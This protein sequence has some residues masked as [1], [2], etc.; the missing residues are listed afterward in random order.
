MPKM[1][2]DLEP[3]T[4]HRYFAAEANNRAWELAELPQRDAAQEREML[5]VAHASA[6]HWAAVGTELH[7]MRYTAL[8]AEVHALVGDGE[9]ALAYATQMRD[10]FLAQA[11][12]P[13]WELALT[14][15]IY[16]HAAH[17]AGRK[18]A[19][20]DSYRLAQQAMDAIAEDEDRE[21]VMKTFLQVP[22]A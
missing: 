20:A 22:K 15:T 13:D 3:A 18:Q 9:R 17:A 1:P 7:R 10:F 5:D 19:H 6:W 14:H 16:A 8:L 12:T 21:I 2:T 4:W 11:D